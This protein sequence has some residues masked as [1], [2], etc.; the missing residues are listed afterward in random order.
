[1]VLGWLKNCEI[2]GQTAN[3]FAT[4]FCSIF[5]CQPKLLTWPDA[6]E[7]DQNISENSF[8]KYHTCSDKLICR[9]V[10]LHSGHSQLLQR[11][12]VP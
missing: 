11:E 3:R 6:F 12:P 10:Q 1:M 5:Q 9:F 8:G 4:Q 2:L 7:V